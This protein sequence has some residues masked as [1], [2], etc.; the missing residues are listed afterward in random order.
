MLLKYRILC[1]IQLALTVVPCGLPIYGSEYGLWIFLI[2][3]KLLWVPVLN[4]L[5]IL[6]LFFLSIVAQL[7]C[8]LGGETFCYYLLLLDDRV[9]ILITSY[10]LVIS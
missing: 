7:D 2:L 5:L 10:P 6:I 3:L 8:N 4:S 9:A 1:Q